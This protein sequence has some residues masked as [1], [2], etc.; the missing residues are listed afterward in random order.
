MDESQ[1]P[2]IHIN[3]QNPDSIIP[4]HQV[5]AHLCWY[6]EVTVREVQCEANCPPA[7]PAYGPANA[8]LPR[9]EVFQS[10]FMGYLNIQCTLKLNRWP[11]VGKSPLCN[12]RALAPLS[13]AKQTPVTQFSR[14][15]HVTFCPHLNSSM[16]K[17][18]PCCW[19]NM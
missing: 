19:S 12:S 1:V 6:V 11:R 13:H 16:L 2:R 17:R 8:P 9:S 15:Q 10:T 18:Q 5:G 4:P 14:L 3:D 7:C